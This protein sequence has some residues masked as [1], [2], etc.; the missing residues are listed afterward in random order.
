MFGRSNVIAIV[1]KCRLEGVLITHSLEYIDVFMMFEKPTCKGYY[2]MWTDGKLKYDWSQGKYQ[3]FTSK[4]H[5]PVPHSQFLGRDRNV[6]GPARINTNVETVFKYCTWTTETPSMDDVISIRCATWPPDAISFATRKRIHGWPDKAMISE[7]VRNG[8]D[9]VPVGH[10][11]FK[12]DHFWRLSFSRAEAMLIRSWTPTQ[13]IVYHMIRSLA[14][15]ELFVIFHEKDPEIL[16]NYHIKTLMLW[17]CESKSPDWWNS[18]C[19]IDLCAQL[20]QKLANWTEEKKCPSYF[21][22]NYN[23]FGIHL[24]RKS[25]QYHETIE[26]LQKFSKTE[27][28]TTWFKNNYVSQMY[29]RIKKN[30]HLENLWNESPGK[31]KS[32]SGLPSLTEIKNLHSSIAEM[33]LKFL[34]IVNCTVTTHHYFMSRW[35]KGLYKALIAHNHQPETKRLADFA[36]VLLRLAWN[37]SEKDNIELT[38]ADILDLL[39]MIVVRLSN[40]D[41]P[42]SFKSTLSIPIQVSHVYSKWYYMKGKELLCVPCR[43]NTIAYHI[44]LKTCKR[45]F[46]SA[47]SVHDEYSESVHCSS[48][49]YLAALYCVGEGNHEKTSKH[50]IQV[51]QSAILGGSTQPELFDYHSILFI[52]E[53]AIVC[54]L[55]QLLN[56]SNLTSRSPPRNEI[57]P[58]FTFATLYYLVSCRR[59]RHTGTRNI[60]QSLSSSADT[61]EDIKFPPLMSDKFVFAVSSHKWRNSSKPNL[62]EDK[63]A[64]SDSKLKDILLKLSIEYFKKFLNLESELLS[65][66]NFDIGWNLSSIFEALYLYKLENYTALLNLCDSVIP[67][68]VLTLN[69]DQ[70]TVFINHTGYRDI[71]VLCGFQLLFGRNVSFL[72]GLITLVDRDALRP[73]NKREAVNKCR[74]RVFERVGGEDLVTHMD[75]YYRVLYQREHHTWNE[76][77][78]KKFKEQETVKLDQEC[79][80]L[81]LQYSCATLSPEFV[82]C[83]LRFQSLLELNGET[84][85]LVA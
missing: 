73:E 55:H 48:N 70:N 38:N 49:A 6:L 12:A 39:S 5:E 40:S 33:E 58:T 31:T 77:D 2:I 62:P 32:M 51:E 63:P 10:P 66:T 83:Y 56:Y 45:F 11:N 23:V 67:A 71:S 15:Q 61:S 19:V 9:F 30:I 17:S 26:Q 7:I 80:D 25:S 85:R 69:S 37:I 43:K 8:C 84:K 24:L 81:D 64:I 21:L 16:S 47:L 53:V 14:K 57:F 13:Q 59:D 36:C 3:Y 78:Y 46:K 18:N 41:Q 68:E 74:N 54:G 34:I 82:I 22:D 65:N 42:S 28:L 72:A 60:S 35:S 4:S 50:L 27:Y 44:W 79:T 20:I 1:D 52:D 76:D 29:S 75:D